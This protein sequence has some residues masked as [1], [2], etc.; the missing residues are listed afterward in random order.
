MW[1]AGLDPF[2]WPKPKRLK[3]SITFNARIRRPL[4]SATGTK[5]TDQLPLMLSLATSGI[6]CRLGRRFFPSPTLIHSHQAIQTPDAL[7]IPDQTVAAIQL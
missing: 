2:P 3:P 4:Q 7:A 6:G 5:S 1:Q